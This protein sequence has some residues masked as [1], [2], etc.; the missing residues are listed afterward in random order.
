MTGAIR[1]TK[2]TANEI[3]PQVMEHLDLARS[4]FERVAQHRDEVGSKAQSNGGP[5]RPSAWAQASAELDRELDWFTRANIQVKDLER[6]LVDFPA[7]LDGQQVLLCWQEGE[8][9]VAF[10]HTPEAGFPGR[11]P[12]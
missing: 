9:E 6:G 1:Y 3:L 2:L 4:A 10:W 5:P 11:R 8:P 12:L 7:V